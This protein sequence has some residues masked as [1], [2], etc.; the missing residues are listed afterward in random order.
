LATFLIGLWQTSLER[1][2]K[3]R[4]AKEWKNREEHED[5]GG[6]KDPENAK[7]VLC[8]LSGQAVLSVQ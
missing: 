5:L 8:G 2:S 4:E 1:Q 3:A 6:A 7:P